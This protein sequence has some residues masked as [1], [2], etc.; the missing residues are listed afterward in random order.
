MTSRPPTE[1]HYRMAESA[2]RSGRALVWT[3]PTIERPHVDE[4]LLRV[5]YVPQPFDHVTGHVTGLGVLDPSVERPAGIGPHLGAVGP[6]HDRPL[7]FWFGI[8]GGPK[9][10]P[11]LG[12]VVIAVGFALRVIV[13]SIEGHPL[14]VGPHLAGGRVHGFC[15]SGGES[16]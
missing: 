14:I 1:R 5:S 4:R 2:A 12:T 9:G 3:L 11:S 15:R 8:G 13:E 10:W 6:V 16:G 7:A